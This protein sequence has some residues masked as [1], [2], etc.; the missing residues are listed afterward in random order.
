MIS[1][2]AVQLAQ[3]ALLVRSEVGPA[4]P[5]EPAVG[6]ERGGGRLDPAGAQLRVRVHEQ[7]Q[8][9][10]VERGENLAEGLVQGPGLAPGVPGRDENPGP[11]AGRDLR[12][13][14]R[15]VVTDDQHLVRGP[16]LLPQ[17]QQR[18]ADRAGLVVSRY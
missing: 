5:A 12:R 18:G 15:A 6:R 7:D 2:D 4:Y 3:G 9:G 1:V 17:R 11:A 13:V 8:V 16:G 10:A 14:V